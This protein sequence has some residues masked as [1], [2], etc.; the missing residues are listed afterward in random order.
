MRQGWLIS[1]SLAPPPFL[2]HRRTDGLE[3]IGLSSI[4]YKK[5][6]WRNQPGTF[7]TRGAIRSD[8]EWYGE[9]S[10]IL[11]YCILSFDRGCCHCQMEVCSSPPP[12]FAPYFSACAH[13]HTLATELLQGRALWR[14]TCMTFVLHFL[15]PRGAGGLSSPY[16]ADAVAACFHYCVDFAFPLA[17]T[18]TLQGELVRFFSFRQLATLFESIL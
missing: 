10:F 8:T 5:K 3:R 9:K 6:Q 16:C 14:L 13:T 18:R 17:R 1:S 15:A 4:F 2:A 7:S 12:P 11:K